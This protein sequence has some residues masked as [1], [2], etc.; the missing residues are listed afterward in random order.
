MPIVD[1][2]HPSYPSLLWTGTQ[3]GFRIATRKKA[4]LCSVVW[5]KNPEYIEWRRR[6]TSGG[7][8][9]KMVTHKT[10]CKCRARRWVANNP[11]KA[12]YKALRGSANRRKIPFRLSFA[13]FLVLCEKTGYL[14]SKGCEADKLHV[15][16]IDH[17]KGYE[18]GNI[19][20]I[21]CRENV[22]KGNKERWASYYAGTGPCPNPH[23]VAEPVVVAVEE[24]VENPF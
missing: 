24:E 18:D 1:D 12:A 13:Q 8:T 23:H 14:L 4:G 21:T 6:Q 2:S 17:L 11:A 15:D 5:C 7:P 19:R 9:T 10:C 16:R 20:V 22:I 3:W